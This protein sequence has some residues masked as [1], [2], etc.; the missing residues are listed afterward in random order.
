[1]LLTLLPRFIG[2]GCLTLIVCCQCGPAVM[3]ADDE[4]VN[5]DGKRLV[6]GWGDYLRDG[7]VCVVPIED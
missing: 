6:M 5:F 3:L 4:T 2:I 7:K 1:M